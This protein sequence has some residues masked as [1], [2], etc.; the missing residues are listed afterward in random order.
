MIRMKK[1]ESK[2]NVMGTLMF[3]GLHIVFKLKCER[4]GRWVHLYQFIIAEITK[5]NAICGLMK[6]HH[7][8][9]I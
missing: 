8:F 6:F 2:F 9:D 1:R 3:T 4:Q 5:N 7:R